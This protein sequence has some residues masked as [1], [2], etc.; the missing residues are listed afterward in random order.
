MYGADGFPYTKIAGT[1][2]GITNASGSREDFPRTAT[3]AL[4]NV[5]NIRLPTLL[6]EK[7]F[8]SYIK[9][10]PLPCISGGSEYRRIVIPA[11]ISAVAKC[12]A[13]ISHSLSDSTTRLIAAARPFSV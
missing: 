13:N 6:S 11:F 3:L 2:L 8:W 4:L 1:S 10:P 12:A 9:R 5:S 7:I